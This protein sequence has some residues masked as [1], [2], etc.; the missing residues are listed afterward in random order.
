[1]LLSTLGFRGI[2]TAIPLQ[3]RQCFLFLFLWSH[4]P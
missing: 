3:T 1:V 2:S 4:S